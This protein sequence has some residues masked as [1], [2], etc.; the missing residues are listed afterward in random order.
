MTDNLG[1]SAGTLI[2]N[3][4]AGSGDDTIEGNFKNN[5]ITGGAGDDTLTGGRGNDVFDFTVGFGNDVI[6]DFV[7]GTDKLKIKDAQGNILTST[8]FTD[9]TSGADLVITLGSHDITLEGLAA[10]SFDNTF[11]EIT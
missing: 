2:E 5:L 6:T 8:N 4:T 7:V 11:L 1:I 10:V 9:S 3:I